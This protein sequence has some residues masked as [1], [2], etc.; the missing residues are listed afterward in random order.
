MTAVRVALADYLMVRRALGFKLVDHSRVLGD[1]VDH[2]EAAGATTITTELA[3]AWAT[4]PEHTSPVWWAR[5][6]TMVRGFARH[7][8][9]LDGR[10]EVPPSHLLPHGPRR[11]S[12]YLYSDADVEA[13]MAATSKLR[14][15]L[16]TATYTT[17]IGLLAVT[18]MRV[19][20]AIGLDRDG[21]DWREG[22]LTVTGAKFGKSREIPLHPT[23]IDAL[24]AYAKLRDATLPRPKTSSF[25]VSTVGTRLHHANV[26]QT[27]VILVRHAGLGQRSGR[28]ARPHDLRHS[29]CV[30]TVVGWYRDDVDVNSALPAL[31]TYVGHARP[32]NT[33]WYLSAVPELLA[34]AAQRRERKAGERP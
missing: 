33:Y 5:R 7:L 16:R 30:K 27:F 28:Q 11:V 14:L 22:L 32:E 29:F 34:L 19:G 25:F 2:L 10:A 23:T 26:N 20:E 12:P 4:M 3:V 17:L 24:S 21:V 15:P 31:S 9:A 6:L 13:L 1:F 8:R 18:G